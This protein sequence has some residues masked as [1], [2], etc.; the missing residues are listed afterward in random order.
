MLACASALSN[1]SC[2]D[3]PDNSHLLILTGCTELGHLHEC[4]YIPMGGSA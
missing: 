1:P 4:N 3:F 2:I